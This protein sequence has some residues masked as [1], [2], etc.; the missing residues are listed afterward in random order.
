MGTLARPAFSALLFVALALPLAPPPTSASSRAVR[1]I[2]DKAGDR[3]VALAGKNVISARK[4]AVTPVRI[5]RKA[6]LSVQGSEAN[7]RGGLLEDEDEFHSSNPDISISGRGRVT[8][9]ALVETGVRD[10]FDRKMVVA[11]NLRF[12][13]RA[14]CATEEDP[15]FY[16][17]GFTDI[18]GE[19]N[20]RRYVLPAG[21]Y[22]LY[23]IADGGPVRVTLR[24]HGLTGDARITPK[25]RADAI[26]STPASSLD[27][28]N[29]RVGHSYG[30]TYNQNGDE[31]LY[32]AAQRLRGDYWANGRFGVCTYE[33][34]P[35]V[36]AP[37]AYTYPCIGGFGLYMD[38]TVVRT[39]PYQNLLHT[40]MHAV[41]KGGGP[42]GFGG[43]YLAHAAQVN[44]F[45]FVQLQIDMPA[46][47]VTS[48]QAPGQKCERGSGSTDV[49]VRVA[50]LGRTL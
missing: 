40:V 10:M 37:L 12:C 44:Q 17:A 23:A 30:Q 33:G 22:L 38:D 49:C 18:A 25:D 19:G 4:S 41:Q 48:S 3:L 24:L 50:K 47:E 34:E 36:P 43:G 2:A 9:F 1:P 26:V 45:D 5:K 6:L 15:Y 29:T 32:V 42:V 27:E 16:M 39:A 11:A 31:A 13:D 21:R 14:R 46:D 7:M 8:G 20:A 35:P 28:P